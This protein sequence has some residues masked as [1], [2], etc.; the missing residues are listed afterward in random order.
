M[1]EG[2]WGLWYILQGDNIIDHAHIPY[3]TFHSR[4]RQVRLH[5][6]NT[7]VDIAYL[8]NIW[9]YTGTINKG[10][11]GLDL[12]QRRLDFC[13]GGN[14]FVPVPGSLLLNCSRN[15]GV[16]QLRTNSSITKK[17]GISA[18]NLLLMGLS[19]NTPLHRNATR[20]H[21]TSHPWLR[22]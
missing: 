18:I 21:S 2:G 22:C 15:N 17:L 16:S 7:S 3:P 11:S 5:L 13:C 8:L 9:N 10:N 1:K 20:I 12:P 14:P 19:R 4:N 6:N